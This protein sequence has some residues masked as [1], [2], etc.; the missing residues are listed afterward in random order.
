MAIPEFCTFDEREK[1]IKIKDGVKG[2]F[3]S[4]RC[5]ELCSYLESK[6]DCTAVDFNNVEELPDNAF[7]SCKHLKKIIGENVL[8]IG[9][10]GFRT[11]DKLVEV[12]LPMLKDAGDHC[13]YGCEK[14]NKAKLPKL[15]SAGVGC[16]KICTA[17]KKFHYR[18]L[19]KPVSLALTTHD[20]SVWLSC[21]S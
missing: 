8:K 5:K 12:D 17:L 6:S 14:L 1:T 18:N 21:Q 20:V 19:L 16:F 2:Q 10:E 13:F 11:C 7:K 9:N 3:S 4:A 15:E